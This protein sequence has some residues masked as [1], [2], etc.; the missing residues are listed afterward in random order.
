[1]LLW[2]KRMN[3]MTNHVLTRV[4]GLTRAHAHAGR[5]SGKL[6][7][8]K[9]FMSQYAKLSLTST[10]SGYNPLL[11]DFANTSFYIGRTG[12]GIQHSVV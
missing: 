10:Q 9:D 12:W 2:G 1:M 8:T 3:G 4:Q 6:T 5:A 7:K 11:E